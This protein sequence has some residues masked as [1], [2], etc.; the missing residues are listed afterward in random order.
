MGHSVKPSLRVDAQRLYVHS[1][2]P[3]PSLLSAQ[4]R[5][6]LFQ[7]AIPEC[8][9]PARGREQGRHLQSGDNLR[10]R[11][12]GRDGRALPELP[13]VSA[14][15]CEDLARLEEDSCVLVAAADLPDIHTDCKRDRVRS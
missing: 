13:E 1:H 9:A 6:L 12:I 8:A 2:T 3:F 14:A 5:T 15:K 11:N 10:S 4:F 7:N